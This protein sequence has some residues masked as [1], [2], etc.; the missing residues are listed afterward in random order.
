MIYLYMFW[1]Q[2][3]I[4]EGIEFDCLI[5]IVSLESLRSCGKLNTDMKEVSSVV[6]NKRFRIWQGIRTILF[7]ISE[8]ALTN[9]VM[10]MDAKF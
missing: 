10:Q 5:G 1:M 8:A 4:F 6:F 9:S 3:S 2:S 7:I